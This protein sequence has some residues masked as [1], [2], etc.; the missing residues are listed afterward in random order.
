MSATNREK[1]EIGSHPFLGVNGNGSRKFTLA[2]AVDH[3]GWCMVRGLHRP[4]L[5][6]GPQ[7]IWTK[8]ELV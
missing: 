5:R 1:V 6:T 3:D 7:S 4:Q 8:L 2:G